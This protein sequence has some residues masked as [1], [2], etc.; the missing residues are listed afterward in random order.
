[1]AEYDIVCSFCG[2]LDDEVVAMI[3][4]PSA[5]IC[6]E[7]VDLCVDILADG[8]GVVHMQA[9]DLYG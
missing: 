5:Y 7:C 3:A 2:K 4:G 6:D 1:M 9:S 8:R